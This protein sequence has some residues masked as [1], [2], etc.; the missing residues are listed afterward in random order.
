MV[1]DDKFVHLIA[2][3]AGGTAGAI[4]TCPL[5]VVKTRLQSSVASFNVRR[6]IVVQATPASATPPPYAGVNF[7]ACGVSASAN[8]LQAKS[9]LGIIGCLRS[10]IENEGPW[11]LFKG[12]GPNL[13]GVAPS[14]A[15]YFAAYSNTKSFL[16][17]VI[18]PDTPIV[19]MGS[20]S[21]AG[22]VSCSVTN[23]IWFVKTRLQLDQSKAGQQRLTVWQCLRDIV[24]EGGF[25][26]FYKG[27]TASYYGIAETVVH[28]VI[29]EYVKRKLRER[30]GGCS[31]DTKTTRDFLEFMLAGAVSKTCAS[32]LAYPH[33]VAR[34]RLRQPGNKYVRFW[35]TLFLVLR[36]EGWRAWYRGLGTQMVRQIPNTAIMMSTYEAVVYLLTKD[37]YYDDVDDDEEYEE[38]SVEK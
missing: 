1:L 30:R 27:I 20:A 29:Y 25:R 9:G 33:E 12:L 8:P 38:T 21:M 4:V 37:R 28:F 35:Q 6:S 15:I 3:G 32:M 36:Q 14:R 17:G 18:R 24:R 19:H 13:V 26:A 11:A 5:E 34:T 31:C 7:C 23:P 2:G 16:N 22:F 10:I